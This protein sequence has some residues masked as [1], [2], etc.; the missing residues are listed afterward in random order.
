M[1]ALEPLGVVA[2]NYTAIIF[3]LIESCLL[4]EIFKTWHKFSGIHATTLKEQMEGLMVFLKAEVEGEE[5]VTLTHSKPVRDNLK[6]TKRDVECK[7]EESEPTECAHINAVVEHFKNVSFYG[8]RYKVQ[9]PWK[10]N[11]RGLPT[12][13][14]LALGRVSHTAEKLN[15]NMRLF[16]YYNLIMEKEKYIHFGHYLPHRSV[17]K[18]SSMTARVQPVFDESA[19]MEVSTGK[20]Q[21]KTLLQIGL[22]LDDCDNLKNQPRVF[23]HASAV[24]GVTSSPFLLRAVLYFHLSHCEKN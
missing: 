21:K 17:V 24:F 3:P 7:G 4:V 23:H 5:H 2:G 11:V 20:Q 18:E 8:T 14:E 16:N 22:H 6:F 15:I 9:L 1:R 13:H 12:N 10:E 19:K